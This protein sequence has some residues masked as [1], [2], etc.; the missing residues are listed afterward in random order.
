[1][2]LFWALCEFLHLNCFEEFLAHCQQYVS[3]FWNLMTLWKRERCLP[4]SSGQCVYLSPFLSLS[5][6]GQHTSFFSPVRMSASFSANFPWVVYF[7]VLPH[8]IVLLSFKALTYNEKRNLCTFLSV[9]G[10]E[11]PEKIFSCLCLQ[12]VWYVEY[13][14]YDSVSGYLMNQRMNNRSG[15][16]RVSKSLWF[17]KKYMKAF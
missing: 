17:F 3:Y 1:M 9:L 7:F 10:N 11:I 15:N 14:V 2:G 13:M 5:N 8:N 16:C 4:R 12:R 6:L